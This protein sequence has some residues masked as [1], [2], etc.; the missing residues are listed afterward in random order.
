M[1]KYSNLPLFAAGLAGAIIGA[2]CLTALANQRPIP[3]FIIKTAI[4]EC[5]NN[6]GLKAI[7]QQFPQSKYTFYCNNTARFVDVYLAGT[8]N[9]V[10]L[11]QKEKH[12]D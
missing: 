4:N 3:A 2:L 1:N 9:D 7:Q 12:A 8:L 5:K 11:D 10:E 6:D